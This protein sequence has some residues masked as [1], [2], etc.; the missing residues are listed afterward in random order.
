MAKACSADGAIPVQ[1]VGFD[2]HVSTAQVVEHEA[3]AIPDEPVKE[4]KK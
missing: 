1:N 2:V 4:K 3:P